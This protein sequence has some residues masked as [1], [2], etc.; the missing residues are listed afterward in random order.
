MRHLVAI[1]AFGAALIPCASQAENLPPIHVG[2]IYASKIGNG[3]TPLVLVPGLG[4]GPW[5]WK[6][7]VDSLPPKTYTVYEVTLAGFDGTPAIP[8]PARFDGYAKSIVTLVHEQHLRRPIII[9]H[10]M[11]GE[12]ALRIGESEPDFRTYG[13]VIVDAFPIVSA[14]SRP[15][16]YGSDARRAQW[17]TIEAQMNA[18]SGADFAASQPKAIGQMVTDAAA[19]DDITLRSPKKRPQDRRGF[20]RRTRNH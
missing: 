5:V 9:G 17:I 12:L 14:A 13:L 16:E 10:S 15:A 4:C 19:A 6:P 18:S 20:C 2:S 8:G 11:G 1:A 3:P 7:F